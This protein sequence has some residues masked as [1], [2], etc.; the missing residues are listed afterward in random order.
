MADNKKIATNIAEIWL[1]DLIDRELSQCWAES[2]LGAVAV[3]ITTTDTIE[4]MRNGCLSFD[5]KHVH[6]HMLR[7]CAGALEYVDVYYTPCV[8]Q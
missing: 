6:V 3:E 5:I 1:G 2:W 7:W 8:E 4:K